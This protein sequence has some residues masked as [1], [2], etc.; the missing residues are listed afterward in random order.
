[1]NLE[2]EI[3][4]GRAADG[5]VQENDLGTGPTE[6]IDQQRL[7]GVAASKPIRGV[8][9]DAVDLATGN[10]IP[11]PFQRRAKQDRAG[12][13]FIQVAVIRLELEAIGGDALL[14]RRDLAGDRIVARLSLTRH[15]RVERTSRLS[16]G[17]L[18]DPAIAIITLDDCM[19]RRFSRWRVRRIVGTRRA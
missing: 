1:M 14:Q 3:V 13:A 12:V 15:A 9:V 17:S 2:K 16:H 5:A 18:P 11:Q 4:L 10:G 8:D 7:M 6:L 19:W